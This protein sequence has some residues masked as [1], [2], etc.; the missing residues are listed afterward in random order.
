MPKKPIKGSIKW[1]KKKL[2]D[3]GVTYDSKAKKGALEK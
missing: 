1:L 2:D 3:V